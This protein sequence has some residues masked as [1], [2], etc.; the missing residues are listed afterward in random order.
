ME[1][2]I[3]IGIIGAG[4]IGKEIIRQ[5]LRKKWEVVFIVERGGVKDGDGKEVS[6]TLTTAILQL[7]D[8]IFLAIPSTDDGD[9]ALGYIKSAIE[10]D[11]P[12]VT[13]EKGA[14]SNNFAEL[15][16]HLSE[17][18]YSASVG[19]GTRMLKF[20]LQHLSP[21]TEQISLIINGT[22][23]F[24]CAEVSKGRVLEEVVK[25]ARERGFTE[26]GALSAEEVIIAELLG[27][28]RKKVAIITNIL[29][30][31]QDILKYSDI[32]T[33]PSIEGLINELS[34]KRFVATWERIPDGWRNELKLIKIDSDSPFNV[35]GGNNVAV[36]DNGPAGTY[37]LTGPG[38]GA[39]PTAQAMIL[40]AIELLKEKSK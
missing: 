32:P 19:G 30:L 7:A 24:V 31:S 20:L 40:D 1:K 39:K 10:A 28:M 27:D 18:G 16:P 8:V 36:I 9:L 15:K 34:G 25:E 3:K 21:E 11:R 29:E 23:N 12:I 26:P 17:I 4:T 13:C 14:L 37:T 22:L 5:A 35:G 38:A 6:I 2:Q 33:P